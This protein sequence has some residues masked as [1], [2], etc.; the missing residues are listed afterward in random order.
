MDSER[1]AEFRAQALRLYAQSRD[2]LARLPAKARIV[3]G[4]F[5]FAAL[6]MALHTALTGKDARL[7]LTVQHGFRTANLSVWI[8]SD[9]AYSSKLVGSTKRKFGVIPA[10]VQGSLSDILPVTAGTHQIRV[11]I[12]SEDGS[13]QEDRLSGDFGRN[14]ERELSVSARPSGLSLGWRATNAATSSSN[15]GWLARYAGALFLT[16]GGS[17]ISALTGFALK[18]LPAHLR[19][20]DPEPKTQSTAA[21]E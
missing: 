15:S 13:T 3:L 19:T 21:A 9:L 4:L 5:L 17:I 6:L 14:T 10:S 11:Q 8:D 2:W 18:E 20:R 1:I 16:V 12:E 7:H